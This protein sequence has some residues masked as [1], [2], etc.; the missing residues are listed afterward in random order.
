MSLANYAI[1]QGYKTAWLHGSPDTAY[2]VK[3]P[4]YFATAFGRPAASSAHELHYGSA[5]FQ[6][7]L[8]ESQEP[9]SAAGRDLHLFIRARPRC[10]PAAISGCRSETPVF[11]AAEGM[12]TPTMFQLPPDVINGVV[13]P[14]RASKHRIAAQRSKEVQ[15]K[16]GESPG[17]VFPAGYDLAKIIEAGP[18][19]WR[20]RSGKVRDARQISKTSRGNWHDHLQRHEGHAGRRSPS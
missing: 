12:D 8:D 16:Y 2:T 11:F 9:E 10:L 14:R 19:R 20:N 17:S 3:L 5:G 4:E 15:E 1:Q 13:L 6:R 18:A 7:G